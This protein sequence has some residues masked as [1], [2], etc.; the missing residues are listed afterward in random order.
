MFKE[1]EIKILKDNFEIKKGNLKILVLCCALLSVLITIFH[2]FNINFYIKDVIIPFTFMVVGYIFL[3]RKNNLE[4]NKK[5]YLLLIPISLILLSDIIVKID[6]SNMFLNVIV[7]PILLTSFYLLLINKNYKITRESFNLVF[8]L[9]PKNIFKNLNFIKELK[10]E[11]SDTK[12]SKY[13]NVLHGFLIGLPIATILLFLLADADQYFGEFVKFITKFITSIFETKYVLPNILILVASFIILFSI[14]INVLRNKDL[15]LKPISYKESNN[16]VV[17]TILMIINFV[18]IL[19]L[20]SEISKLT[21]NFLK[22]PVEYTYAQ[23][24]RE[25]F[26]Q[27]LMVTSINFIVLLYFLYKTEII[28]KSNLIKNLLLLLIGFSIILIFNSYYR[29][30]LYVGAYGLTIL[31]LQVILFL[32]M[33]LTLFI[34]L[35]K[36]II[37]T[38]KDK[39]AFIFSIVLTS[40]YILNLYICTKDFIKLIKHL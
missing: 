17:T 9:F 3:I 14:F 1:K 33:E 16:T 28:K 2:N 37:S 10:V 13:L 39:D 32:A 27:L 38:I 7:L 5:A 26:F 29:M 8:K 19:F 23:Y 34:V 30:F 11:T 21:I 22:L 4:K 20:I 24:A 18:F 15:K 25:G 40:F 6:Y 31:R 35:I 12:R 36:K